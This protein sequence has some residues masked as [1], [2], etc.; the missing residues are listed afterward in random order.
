MSALIKLP[1][2]G[3]TG[4]LYLPYLHM[5]RPGKDS[6]PDKTSSSYGENHFSIP[7]FGS[8]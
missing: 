8:R 1:V 3:M 6:Y 7:I 4:M 5:L 2:I